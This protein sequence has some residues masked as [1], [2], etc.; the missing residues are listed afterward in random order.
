MISIIRN[1]LSYLLVKV[2]RGHRLQ[3]SNLLSEHGLY[4]GQEMVLDRLWEQDGLTMSELA[5]RLKIKP[6]SA[7]KMVQRMA[8]SNL[9]ETRQSISDARVTQVFLTKS[10]RKLKSSIESDWTQVDEAMFSQLSET[11][12]DTMKQL[13]EK[14]QAGQRESVYIQV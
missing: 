13:L 8:Q 9:V 6:P 3:F 2:T 1:S 4:V 10:G 7:T 5:E 11:E 14:I 12:K